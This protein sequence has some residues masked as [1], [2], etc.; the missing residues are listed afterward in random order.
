[1]GNNGAFAIMEAT[2]IGAADLGVLD[3]RLCAVLCEPYRDMDID[4]GGKCGLK[5]KDGREVEEVII[6]AMGEPLPP[7][8]RSKRP[9]VWGGKGR[10]AKAWEAYDE[11]VCESFLDLMCDRFGWC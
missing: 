8:P 6:M 3:E 2:V 1:M 5:T 10:A 4:H 9:T 11:A 7:R